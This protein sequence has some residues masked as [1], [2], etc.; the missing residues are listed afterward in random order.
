MISRR[1]VCLL[2]SKV[3]EDGVGT[4][5]GL[6]GRWERLAPLL[7]WA[8]GRPVVDFDLVLAYERAGRPR[9]SQENLRANAHLHFVLWAFG[10]APPQTW[11]TE[12]KF[13]QEALQHSLNGS[14]IDLHMQ[15]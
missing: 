8:L 15:R 11:S 13:V 7:S 1:M 12:R 2:F 4:R 10:D 9:I 3:V 6:G 14:G 5:L